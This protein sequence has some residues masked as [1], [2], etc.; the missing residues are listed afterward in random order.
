MMAITSKKP[1]P[2]KDEKAEN[3][4]PAKDFAASGAVIEP[5]IVERVD[6]SHA[7][8]DDNPRAN[9][10]PNMN[11]IDF[12]NPSGLVPQEESVIENLKEA[13]AKPPKKQD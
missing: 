2:A 7:S 4:A 9:S 12:N 1:V 8:V 10:T 3:L 5:A 13:G 11:R 6:M